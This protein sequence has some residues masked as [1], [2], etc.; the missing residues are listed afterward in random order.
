MATLLNLTERQIKIWFQNRRMKFKKEQKGKGNSGSSSGGG[1]KSP[2]PPSCS[3]VTSSSMSPSPATAATANDDLLSTVNPVSPS[4]SLG[5]H[6]SDPT[7][8]YEA[9]N[10]SSSTLG[11]SQS[12]LMLDLASNDSKCPSSVATNKSYSG[13]QQYDIMSPYSSSGHVETDQE[14]PE[15]QQ[16]QTAAFKYEDT[17]IGILGSMEQQQQQHYSTTGFANYSNS[18]SFQHPQ[19]CATTG[20]HQTAYNNVNANTGSYATTPYLNTNLGYH[21]FTG[22]HHQFAGRGYPGHHQ[23]GMFN[24]QQ[25]QQ[26]HYQQQQQQTDMSYG[27]SRMPT[28]ANAY[29]YHGEM[30]TWP[31]S[32]ATFHHPQQ[33]TQ[34]PPSPTI[35][36]SMDCFSTIVES[37]NVN[38]ET[39]RLAML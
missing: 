20:H 32:T 1:D 33:T 12:N 10:E 8:G 16:R 17:K 22:F 5:S 29:Q 30:T 19:Y 25:T 36:P 23:P 13:G 7:S 39:S 2:S 37:S 4:P 18:S 31:S 6:L 15:R 24:Q 35:T 26:H 11:T 14:S 21:H 34:V 9:A 28:T 38:Q 27:Q 3:A